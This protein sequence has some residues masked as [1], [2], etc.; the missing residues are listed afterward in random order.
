[1]VTVADTG[2]GVVPRDIDRIFSPSDQH[3][4][5]SSLPPST[6]QKRLALGLV[7]AL[8]GIYLLITFGPFA[9]VVLRR[10]DAF[11]PIYTT[12]V[13]V[14]DSMTAILLYAQFSILRLR[15]TLVLASGY[16]F[17]G[18]FM[19]LYA[20]TFPGVFA[21]AGLIGGTQSAAWLYV[22]WKIGFPLFVL[23]YA[24]SKD[25]EPGKALWRGSPRAGIALSVG[26]AALL[27]VAGAFVCIV[28]EPWLPR[29]M[30]DSRV[31]GPNWT[32]V[33]IPIAVASVAALAT[34]LIRR[35]SMLDLWLVVVMFL[36]V[37]EVPLVYYPTPGRFSVSFYTVRILGILASGIVLIVMVHEITTLYVRLLQ[38]LRDQRREREARLFTGDAVAASI[39]HE[40]KQPLTAIITTADAGSFFLDRDVPDLDRVK[41]ALAR[42]A[43]DGHRAGAVIENIR[44]TFRNEVRNRTLL[45]INQLIRDALLLEQ[46]ELRKHRILVH[47]EPHQ[48]LPQV[49][50]D[51]IQLQQVL[52]NLIA[53]AIA[54]MAAR[55][56][57]RILHLQSTVHADDCVLV[58][59]ADTGPGVDAHDSERIFNA[60]F[61][62]KPD[63]MGM[64]LSICRSIVEAHQGRLWFAPN[65]PRGAVF[66][67]TLGAESGGRPRPGLHEP[68]RSM[69]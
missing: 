32:Y 43:A 27:I 52:L 63:G 16:V 59:V 44:E 5:L 34:L 46:D 47:V 18:L 42:I 29:L 60:H 14:N 24:L 19:I 50:A 1:M 2:D 62:T 13:L 25:A 48:H 40:V 30:L 33:G 20:L 7:C 35:R 45:D 10:V 68:S 51:R 38:A 22:V 9:G 17:A 55:E 15:S 12:A 28:G 69:S 49:R 56:E 36:Y 31:L 39:A 54:A 41:E 4:V 37:I 23:G 3:F 26:A 66:R 6:A 58:S 64:G 21:P 53:N 11:I 61:T 8:I 57:P 65:T 67:F